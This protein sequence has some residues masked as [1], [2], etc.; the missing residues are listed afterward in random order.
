MG[1]PKTRGCPYH[2]NIVTL[3]MKRKLG[4]VNFR[5]DFWDCY[6]EHDQ[7]GIK[8]D[9]QLTSASSVTIPEILAKSNL[10]QFPSQ[11]RPQGLLALQYGKGEDLGNLEAIGAVGANLPPF[12]FCGSVGPFR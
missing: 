5:K 6:L 3:E 4:R 10:A 8:V 7:Q 11:L 9:Q 2:C 12:S 1:M